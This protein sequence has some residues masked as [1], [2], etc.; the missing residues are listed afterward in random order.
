MSINSISGRHRILGLG[1]LKLSTSWVHYFQE[2]LIM[3]TL[4]STDAQKG[5]RAKKIYYMSNFLLLFPPSDCRCAVK[6]VSSLPTV[7][8]PSPQILFFWICS[9]AFDIWCQAISIHCHFNPFS[10][11][12]FI[13][14]KPKPRKREW[15]LCFRMYVPLPKIQKHLE[16]RC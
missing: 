3:S 13:L 4:G 15:S 11:E 10:L 7:P 8:L 2:N 6:C 1:G 5:N 12:V 16:P 14:F 9:N